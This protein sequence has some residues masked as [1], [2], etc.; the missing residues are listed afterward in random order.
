MALELDTRSVLARLTELGHDYT[1][2]KQAYKASIAGGR[3]ALYD[4]QGQRVTVDASSVEQH[5]AKAGWTID[6]PVG[7]ALPRDDSDAAEPSNEGE[8]AAE[9]PK[10]KGKSGKAS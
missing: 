7:P 2:Q 4:P 3:C 10:P 5:F 9:A 8:P 1:P 6:A